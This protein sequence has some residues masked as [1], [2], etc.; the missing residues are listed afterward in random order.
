MDILLKAKLD[1]L[2]LEHADQ[3][4]VYYVLNT[5]PT[6]NWDGGVGFVTTEMIKERLP[7]ADL[8]GSKILLCGT[9]P[10]SPL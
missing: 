3:F 6:G 10:P 9:S 8:P 5:P 2:A 1:K 4:K 7:A